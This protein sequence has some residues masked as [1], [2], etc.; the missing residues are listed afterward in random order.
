M[1]VPKLASSASRSSFRSAPVGGSRAKKT[2][3]RAVMMWKCF[4]YGRTFPKTR[5]RARWSQKATAPIAWIRAGGETGAKSSDRAER[6]SRRG[7]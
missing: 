7:G 2:F 1:A 6:A 4:P 3:G 5:M